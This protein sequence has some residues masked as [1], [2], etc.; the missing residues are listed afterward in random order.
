MKK[1]GINS[2]GGL[3]FD[4]YPHPRFSSM[5]KKELEKRIFEL[6]KGE[7]ARKKRLTTFKR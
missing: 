7:K 5:S 1:V 6:K 2:D 3:M 4:D